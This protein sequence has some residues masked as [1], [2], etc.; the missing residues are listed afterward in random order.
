MLKLFSLNIHFLKSDNQIFTY[1][2]LEQASMLSKYV[3]HI[4]LHH[5]MNWHEDFALN[6]MHKIRVSALV[7]GY[8]WRLTTGWLAFYPHVR[9]KTFYHNLHGCSRITSYVARSRGVLVCHD[10]YTQWNIVWPY[11]DRKKS[12]VQTEKVNK[13][14]YV[15]RLYECL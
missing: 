6:R 12:D 11:I 8:S 7:Q 1:D 14:F 15:L 9:P 5:F 2:I 3:F 4:K 13:A 10:W